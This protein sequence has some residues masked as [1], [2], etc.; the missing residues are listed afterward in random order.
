MGQRSRKQIG[1][2]DLDTKNKFADKISEFKCLYS[3]V[4]SIFNKKAEI[5]VYLGNFEIDIMLFT[6]CFITEDHSSSEYSFTGYQAFV[7]LKNRGG[8]CIYVKNSV[9]CYEVSPP[10]QTEDSCWV[11]IPTKNNV[12]RLYACVYR[13]PNSPEENNVKLLRNIEWAKINFPEVFLVGDMNL[14][15]INWHTNFSGNM[16]EA[17]FLDVLDDAGLEQLVSEPTRYRASQNPSLLDLI[18][19]SNPSSVQ[20]IEI[21]D[22]FGK[23]DH[24]K[25]EFTLK[26]EYEP[27]KSNNHI[28]NYRKINENIFINE[29]GQFKAEN[30]EHDNIDDMYGNFVNVVRYAI[31]KSVPKFKTTER[32]IAPWS[33]RKIKR[34]SLKKRKLWDKYKH[35]RS[36]RNYNAYKTCLSQFNAEKTRAI[37]N[38]EK[39]IICN[40][41]TNPKKYYNYVSRKDRYAKQQIILEDAGHTH[42][43]PGKCSEVL[44]KYFS[45]VYTTGNSNLNVD[46]SQITNYPEIEDIVVTEDIIRELI[47]ELDITKSTGHDGIPSFLI[48][49]FSDIFTP[50]LTTIFKRS[51]REGIVPKALKIANVVPL[52]KG[53]D[54]TSPDNYRPVSLTPV[55]AK[56]FE[57]I[58]KKSVEEHVTREQILSNQQHGFRKGRSTSSNLLQF[59]NDIANMANEASSISIIYTDLRKA[60]DGVPYD[61]LVYKLSK[62]GITGRTSKWIESFLMERQ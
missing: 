35:T 38:Y 12:K 62:Y 51:Y 44:N 13:S 22:P 56:I 1:N 61:L 16:Y 47:A 18:L 43:E 36:Q 7:A 21:S 14:P 2:F 23:S 27:L 55:I 33:N 20:N 46:V 57:K 5:E 49:K 28:Y 53:G 6:E 32:K 41:K 9:P 31:E 54:K 37:L 50:I 40:K 24:C 29:M 25:I 58:I 59:T 52:H 60:F 39:N 19:T 26:T 10:D 15:S 3:N 48:Q 4:Q 45:S 30:V 34:L 11:V 42:S 17:S 8:S